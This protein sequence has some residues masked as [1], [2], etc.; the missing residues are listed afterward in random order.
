MNYREKKAASAQ[1]KTEYVKGLDAV[2]VARQKVCEAERFEYTKD[3]FENQEKY[4][5]DFINMLGWPLGT[6]E[7]TKTPRVASEE[8]ISEEDGYSIYRMR[9]EILAE[10]K[11]FRKT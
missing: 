6:E 7:M 8:L 9:F 11:L 10:S 5:N 3:I 2:I 4:R 1:Y